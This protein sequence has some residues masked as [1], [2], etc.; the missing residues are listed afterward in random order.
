L[1][2]TTRELLESV[3]LSLERDVGPQL[4]DKWAASTLRSAVQLLKHAAVRVEREH[5]ILIEDNADVRSVLQSCRERL[6]AS[7]DGS[8]W[9]R[10][11]DELLVAPEPVPHDAAGLD[12]RNEA[13]QAVV[14]QL[15]RDRR[16]LDAVPSGHEIHTD[17]G[18]Y[19]RRRLE[20][21][22]GL[23]FPAFTGAPF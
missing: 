8:G 21:E 18:R 2:P 6:A 10:I 1:R 13:Y 15:L 5:A 7:Q 9:C 14:E 22:Q 4:T 16:A 19:L 3:A 11:I 12:Q 17:V 20:R 23:Y